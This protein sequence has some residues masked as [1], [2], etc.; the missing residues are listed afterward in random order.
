M[1][2]RVSVSVKG[3]R[4][5]VF[6]HNDF[7]KKA[8]IAHG[9]FEVV[10]H[11]LASNEIEHIILEELTPLGESTKKRVEEFLDEKVKLA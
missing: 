8:T 1:L 10:R 6:T 9:E 4:I 2:R 3:A 5:S 7:N 11:A